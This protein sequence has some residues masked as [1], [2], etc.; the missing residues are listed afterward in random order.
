[1]SAWQPVQCE[2]GYLVRRAYEQRCG[3][4]G[5]PLGPRSKRQQRALDLEAPGWQRITLNMWKRP[6]LGRDEPGDLYSLAAAW[7]T[8]R[9]ERGGV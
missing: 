5:R 7:H 6:G 9:R 2:C 3:R 8:M 4:C 1:V